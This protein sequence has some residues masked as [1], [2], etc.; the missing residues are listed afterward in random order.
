MRIILFFDLPIETNK[1]VS[2]YTKFRKHLLKSGFQMLQK[3]VY[4]KLAVT[5]AKADAI[6]EQ[7]KRFLPSKG[8]IEVLIITEKQ[9]A[10]II[11]ILGE[12]ESSIISDLN[13]VVEL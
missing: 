9:F 7:V 8:H 12:H 4:I 3:S 10:N 13:E 1:E 5:K 2:E 11:T 6:I